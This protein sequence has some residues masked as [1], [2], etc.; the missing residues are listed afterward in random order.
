MKANNI[1]PS[2]EGAILKLGEP[3]SNLIDSAFDSLIKVSKEEMD[4]ILEEL[5]K[6]GN[7]EEYFQFTEGIPIFSPVPFSDRRRALQI[8]DKYVKLFRQSK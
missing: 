8:R 6:P 3:G 5:Q 4:F 2:I 7:E 1:F